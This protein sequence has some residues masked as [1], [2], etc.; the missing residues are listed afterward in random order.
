M[1]II[2]LLIAASLSVALMFL[3]AFLWAV[4]N[5]QYEDTITP[6]IR[7]LHDDY[8]IKSNNV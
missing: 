6:A 8:N 3:G 5:N 1:S 2:I 4:K 7:I